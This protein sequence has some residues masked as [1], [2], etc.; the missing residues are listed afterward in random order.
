MCYLNNQTIVIV[1]VS[2]LTILCIA[3][4][5]TAYYFEFYYFETDKLVYEVGE[6]IDM[7]AK[8]IADFSQDGWC[9]VSF[10]IV[11]D[12][13]V[14]FADSYYI[15]A[16][17]DIRYLS[18]SH[19]IRP[20]CASPGIDGSVAYVIFNVEIYDGY[21]QGGGDTIPINIT[22]G[23]LEVLPESS[24]NIEFN[25][26]CT[27]KFRIN[28]IHNSNIVLSNS[29]V[30]LAV[31]DESSTEVFTQDF[32]TDTNGFLSLNWSNSFGPPGSYSL[33]ISGNGTLAFSPFSDSLPITVLPAHSNIT[34][35]SSPNII[36]C[37]NPYED[38][39]ELVN[40]TIL[41][42]NMAES[43]LNDSLVIWQTSFS[44]GT[45]DNVGNGFYSASIPFEVPPGIWSVNITAHN[46]L[47]QSST[48]TILIEAIRRNVTLSLT[49][50]ENPTSGAFLVID[51][52]IADSTI[53]TSI[54]SYPILI[55]ISNETMIIAS[56]LHATNVSGAIRALLNI[57]NTFFGSGLIRAT[58]NGTLYHESL[59]Y[60]KSITIFFS[61]N[62]SYD[63]VQ[64]TVLGHVSEAA[65]RVGNAQGD[66][67][68]GANLR[69]INETGATL[70][71]GTT[72]MQGISYIDWLVSTDTQV[73]IHHL[74]ILIETNP[75][76]YLAETTIPIEIPIQYPVLFSPAQTSWNAIRGSNLSLAFTLDS[77]FSFNQSLRI[78][79]DDFTDEFSF[80]F[81][82]MT[83]K[84][85][86]ISV[87]I[88]NNVSLGIHV[89]MIS[90]V[91]V[92][93]TLLETPEIEVQIQGSIDGLVTISPVYYNEI[94]NLT[95][96]LQY[97]NGT[98][99]SSVSTRIFLDSF[100]IPVIS[101]N[102]HSTFTEIPFIL[103]VWVQ[104]GEHQIL[105]EITTAWCISL[106]KSF[107]TIV[108]MRT[109]IVLIIDNQEQQAVSLQNEITIY[110]S[111]SD[112][113]LNSSSGSINNPP[114]ILVNDTISLSDPTD[115]DT[116]LDNC[117]RLS[118]GTNNRSTDCANSRISTSGNGHIPLGL[119]DLIA[120]LLELVA[121]SSSTDLDVHPYEI[122]PQSPVSGPETTK[123]V[124]K[125]RLF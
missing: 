102:N 110:E 46:S 38:H 57:P 9:Y 24:T 97:D 108:W 70:G 118:S 104:P 30:S 92:T 105:F 12:Q 101:L 119:N 50:S 29:P 2:I 81:S 106:N 91:N 62:V 63:I 17:P 13:G 99:I 125:D 52:E 107:R 5:V 94:A 58:S 65:I 83:D 78:M 82:V 20:D 51:I 15:G 93:Y 45:M 75:S 71:I 11:T 95:V 87:I 41:H 56:S 33:A 16:L 103:P 10:S 84:Q 67:I 47:Y 25:S 121:I 59:D 22:R 68:E 124:S 79:I 72:N 39:S 61:A 21:S 42:T 6:T 100:K 55:E 14:V 31:F 43:R 60:I 74:A 54:K 112:I 120:S 48:S 98:S 109:S 64:P 1:S 35:I 32:I 76:I 90:I 85:A 28:S 18:S 66:P 49:C 44:S 86:R 27:L 69:L 80:S 122:I 114:P 40:I 36:L 111:S 23:S 115:L 77:E 53:D 26:N 117:P 96:S 73:G 37:E 89:L 123:S 8:L 88:P 34:V 113:F 116:S 4:P 7:V 3:A 19:T